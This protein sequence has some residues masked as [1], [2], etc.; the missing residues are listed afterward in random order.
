MGCVGVQFIELSVTV[1]VVVVITGTDAVVKYEI[2]DELL[3]KLLCGQPLICV[4]GVHDGVES[5]VITPVVAVEAVAIV[6][7][8]LMGSEGVKESNSMSSAGWTLGGR[9]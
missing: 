9:A 8:P 1:I 6:G 5:S 7:H 4:V 2:L 3:D